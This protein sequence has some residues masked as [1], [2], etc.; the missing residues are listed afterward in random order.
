[1]EEFK[2]LLVILLQRRA[3]QGQGFQADG[4][5]LHRLLQFAPGL[6]EPGKV[7]TDGDAPDDETDAPG[8]K[9]AVCTD[10]IEVEDPCADQ[11]KQQQ[12]QDDIYTK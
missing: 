3:G 10:M 12:D 7:D 1:M 8:E 9:Q 5:G 2:Q 4:D 6:T 11:E